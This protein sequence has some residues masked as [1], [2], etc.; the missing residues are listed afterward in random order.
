ME[1]PGFS[2]FPVDSEEPLISNINLIIIG[3]N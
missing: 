3:Y 2:V 1:G